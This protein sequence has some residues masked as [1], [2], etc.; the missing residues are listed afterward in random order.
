MYSDLVI[1]GSEHDDIGAVLI[2]DHLP[3]LA[4][5]PLLWPVGY[6]KQF[7]C[8]VGVDEVGVVLVWVDSLSVGGW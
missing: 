6:H 8:E 3:E 2:P 1:I 4:G 5:I 7:G